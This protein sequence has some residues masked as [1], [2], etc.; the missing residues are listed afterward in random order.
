MEEAGPSSAGRFSAVFTAGRSL[1]V[2]AARTALPG[3]LKPSHCFAD[4]HFM[5]KLVAAVIV[6][7]LADV[8]GSRAQPTFSSSLPPNPSILRVLSER[9]HTLNANELPPVGG[10]REFRVREYG[11][12]V[13]QINADDCPA[14][15]NDAWYRYKH[16]WLIRARH[17]ADKE[18]RVESE[19]AWKDVKKQCVIYST[20]LPQGTPNF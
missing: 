16:A 7:L 15:F 10:R 2:R 8:A 14:D 3:Q 17:F 19:L 1:F 4:R 18:L 13:Q 5:R 6:L 20:P 12:A 9:E 11:V